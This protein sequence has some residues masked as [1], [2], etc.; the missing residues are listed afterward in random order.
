MTSQQLNL[1]IRRD[2][3]LDKLDLIKKLLYKS[4]MAFNDFWE[5]FLVVSGRVAYSPDSE[6]S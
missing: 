5:E 2:T 6:D 4:F 3:K 1:Q